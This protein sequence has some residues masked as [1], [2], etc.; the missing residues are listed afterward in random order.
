MCGIAGF[1]GNWRK[2]MLGKLAAAMAHRGPDGEGLWHDAKANIGLAHRRL[3]IIDLSTAASQPME[4]VKGRYQTVFNGEIYNYKMLAEELKALGYKFNPHSDTAVLAPLYD[5]YGPAMLEKLEGMFAFAIWDT[6]ERTLFVARDH[7]GIKPLYYAHNADG[8]AFASELKALLPLLEDTSLDPA[9]MAEYI[10]F[11]WTPGERTMLNA[12]RKLRP[13]HYLMLKAGK[14]GVKLEDTRWYA[15]P[16]PA[17]VGGGA[18][19]GTPMYDYKKTPSQLLAV[20]DAV[21]AEQCTSDVPVGAFLSGGVDSSAIVASMVATGNAPANTYC[22]GFE[23]KGFAAEGFEDDMQ[24]AASVAK[25]LGVKFSPMVVEM[26]PLLKRLPTLPAMLDE[27]TADPA[28]LFVEDI[29]A[30]A[31]ADGITVLLSGTGGDDVFSGYRRHQAARLRERLGQTLCQIAG[32]GLNA[33]EP[34]LRGPF[35]RRA[36][37]LMDLFDGDDNRFLLHAFTTNSQ[38]DAFMLLKPNARHH[39]SNGWHNALTA[40]R[41][42]TMG[43]SLMNRLLYMELFGFLPDHNLN[44][45]D[46]A[47]MKAGVEGRVPLT[48]RRILN[49][50]A[51]VPPQKKLHQTAP[52]WFFKQA[53]GGRLP[54]SVVKRS[55]AGF[56]APIRSWLTTGPGKAMMEEALFESRFTKEWYHQPSLQTFWKSTLTGQVDGT[57]TALAIAMQAWWV[58]SLLRK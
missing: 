8:F 30:R 2:P 45:A 32:Q 44:Y 24:F 46:K 42:E 17:L 39:V 1:L 34:L 55:K 47:A 6:K 21:V 31:R 19:Y 29:A 15:P 52:K 11:L 40:A 54:Q 50:M 18:E 9:A 13:G 10:T 20:L 37:R 58:E 48:D 51:D 35:K 53:V 25:H 16:L 56:G 33:L 12:V 28:P 3:S 14:G 38:P 4:G 5:K 49:F 23:G 22:I 27:P 41:A 57:Y 36:Q 43:H 26:E 7:A